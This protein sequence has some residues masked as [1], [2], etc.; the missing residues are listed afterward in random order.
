MLACLL[1][2]HRVG[3]VPELN[4]SFEAAKQRVMA[5]TEDCDLMLLLRMRNADKVRLMWKR[6]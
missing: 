6:A 3:I 5:A 1:R 2:D 4:E